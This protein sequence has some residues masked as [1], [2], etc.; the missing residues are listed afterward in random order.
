[1]ATMHPPPSAPVSSRRASLPDRMLPP[2]QSPAPSSPGRASP[3]RAAYNA[4]R[5]ASEGGLTHIKATHMI[6]V[7]GKDA[8]VES[9]SQM[10]NTTVEGLEADLGVEFLRSLRMTSSEKNGGEWI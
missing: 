6:S 10:A 9:L 5:R 7:L 8:S 4:S 3:V 1:M 2:A